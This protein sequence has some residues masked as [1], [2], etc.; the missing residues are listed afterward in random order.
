MTSKF[1][2]HKINDHQIKVDTASIPASESARNLGIV[3]DKNLCMEDQIRWICQ[4]VYFHMLLLFGIHY[5]LISDVV[6]L[7]NHL[8]LC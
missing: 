7:S 8:R 4:S 1:H 2:Q 3:F 6:T 5:L